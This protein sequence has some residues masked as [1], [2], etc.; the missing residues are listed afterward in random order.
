MPC[1]LCIHVQAADS[2]N[3]LEAGVQAGSETRCVCVCVCVCWWVGGWKNGNLE[4]GCTRMCM[5]FRASFDS[6]DQL[7]S[8][9]T[10]MLRTRARLLKACRCRMSSCHTLSF[11]NTFIPQQ[12]CPA[13]SGFQGTL[14]PVFTHTHT[15][16]PVTMLACL[17]VELRCGCDKTP[18][19][20]T[21][22]CPRALEPSLCH[23][24]EHYADW[25]LDSTPA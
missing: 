16:T 12:L 24:P 2:S 13:K 15:L 10:R 20:M 23:I 18:C 11:P 21:L 7:E 1:G 6:N 25:P 3:Q 8:L 4:V 5:H 9:S 14:G 17:D 19:M 22:A